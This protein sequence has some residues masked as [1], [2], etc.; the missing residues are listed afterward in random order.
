MSSSLPLDLRLT[1]SDALLN[2]SDFV[3]AVLLERFELYFVNN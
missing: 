1:D 2:D 3:S